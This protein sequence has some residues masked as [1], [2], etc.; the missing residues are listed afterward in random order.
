MTCKW[1]KK[2]KNCNLILTENGVLNWYF[3]QNSDEGGRG[4]KRELKNSEIQ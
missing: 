3:E 4:G 1:K 2:K